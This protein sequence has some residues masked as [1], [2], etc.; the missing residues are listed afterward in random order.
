ML[1]LDPYQWYILKLVSKYLW[2]CVRLF[3][4]D[5]ILGFFDSFF[6]CF[7]QLRNGF[8]NYELIEKTESHNHGAKKYRIQAC[9]P[10]V[11]FD[12]FSPDWIAYTL[13]LYA[14]K[15]GCIDLLEWSL[16]INSNSLSEGMMNQVA[17]TAAEFGKT[18]CLEFILDSK[19]FYQLP[20]IAVRVARGG[21]LKI[22]KKLFKKNYPFDARVNGYAARQ[23][24]LS[25]IEWTHSI[26]LGWK[27]SAIMEAAKAGHI[28]I[29]RWLMHNNI[30]EDFS[31]IDD[32]LSYNVISFAPNPVETLKWMIDNT[33]GESIHKNSLIAIGKKGNILIADMLLSLH[34]DIQNL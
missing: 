34:P 5:N 28:F 19:K 16:I 31:S 22:L 14:A 7:Y 30:I 11:D 24:H 13:P 4:K 27:D 18:E 10:S 32:N 8:G 2:N 25:I 20:I 23:G 6:A 17:A 21:Q 15:Y 1:K 3:F 29:L 26:G 9:F 12:L 33:F